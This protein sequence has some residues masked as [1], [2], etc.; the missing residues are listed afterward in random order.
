MKQGRQATGCAGRCVQSVS[1]A[2]L[3]LRRAL[4]RPD[5]NRSAGCHPAGAAPACRG[6]GADLRSRR[7]AWGEAGTR[8]RPGQGRGRSAPQAP[9]GAGVPA[10]P[11]AGL[12]WD[13]AVDDALPPM[14][15]GPTLRPSR[16]SDRPAGPAAGRAQGHGG[17]ARLARHIEA[18]VPKRDRAPG[19]HVLRALRAA[20]FPGAVRFL[21]GIGDVR[22]FERPVT[23]TADPGPVPGGCS[24]GKTARRGAITRAGNSR[25]RH[26]LLDGARTC[27]LPAKP[28]AGKLF[29]LRDQSAEVQDIAWTGGAG[30]QS[31]GLTHALIDLVSLR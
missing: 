11:R 1:N 28:G 13:Q 19:V 16:P 15:A 20:A 17:A 18:L 25:V 21:A 3:P 27:R 4:W 6:I 30:P 10:A 7:D 12:P 23:L 8:P 2:W 24:A 26:K 9:A 5:E 14:A 29:I 22:R 31:D